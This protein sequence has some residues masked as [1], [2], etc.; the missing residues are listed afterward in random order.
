MREKGLPRRKC[1]LMDRVYDLIK[2]CK[3]WGKF[4]LLRL[5]RRLDARSL[6]KP[7]ILYNA[8]T[9]D[10]YTACSEDRKETTDCLLIDKDIV[11][12]SFIQAASRLAVTTEAAPERPA[13]C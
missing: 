9:Q 1:D 11:R 13:R 4:E 10:S 12:T 8:L 6:A 7:S 3:N 5:S 2:S